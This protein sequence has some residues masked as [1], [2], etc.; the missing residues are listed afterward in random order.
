MLLPQ[1]EKAVQRCLDL[2]QHAQTTVDEAGQ[3][4][5]PVPGFAEE[6]SELQEPIDTIKRHWYAVEARLKTLMIQGKG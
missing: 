6:W 3:A 4:L 5:C 2:L 1:H